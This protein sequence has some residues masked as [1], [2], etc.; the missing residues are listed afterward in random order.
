MLE[1]RTVRLAD[2]KS[3]TIAVI[4]NMI[5]AGASTQPVE[6]IVWANAPAGKC[7]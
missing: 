2:S 6:H 7:A 1:L 4:M 3:I 5:D